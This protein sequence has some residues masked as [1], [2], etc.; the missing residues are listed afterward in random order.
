MDKE[1]DK[2]KLHKVHNMQKVYFSNVMYSIKDKYKRVYI[3]LS[4]ANFPPPFF[5]VDKNLFSDF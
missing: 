3:Y 5:K 2:K 4:I 1:K